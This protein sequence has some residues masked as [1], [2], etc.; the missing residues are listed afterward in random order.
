MQ[1]K[2]VKGKQINFMIAAKKKH[3]NLFQ[4]IGQMNFERKSNYLLLY[5]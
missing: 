3:K 4:I 1:K 2:N 5:Y